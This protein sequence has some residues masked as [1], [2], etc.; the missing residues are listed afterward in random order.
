MLIIILHFINCSHIDSNLIITVWM[1]LIINACLIVLPDD[2]V[3]LAILHAPVLSELKP[4]ISYK[5][6]NL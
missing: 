6:H 4:D 1:N 5:V 3:L 2:C